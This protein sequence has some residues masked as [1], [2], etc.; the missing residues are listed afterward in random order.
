MELPSIIL[1]DATG[2]P[3]LIQLPRPIINEPKAILPSY[4][5]LVVPPSNLS[6][7]VGVP[8]IEEELI[9][10]AEQE[11]E[12]RGE[13]P[14]PKPQAAEVTRINIPFTD[15]EVPVPKEEIL[16]TAGTTAGV[17]VIATLTVTSL[18]KQ[19]VK[20]MKPIIMQLAKRIQKKLNGNN[21]GKEAARTDLQDKGK[22]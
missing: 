13:P 15:F 9:A 21:G 6:P 1:P 19:T 10:Q 18:F 22:D 2:I 4:K 17:S 12:E 7:P 20:V 11:R 3:G 16:I 5:P 8:T 14:K